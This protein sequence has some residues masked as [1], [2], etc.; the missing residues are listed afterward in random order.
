[1]KINFVINKDYDAEVFFSLL[2]NKHWESRISGSGIN[3]R[4]ASKIHNAK[5]K[6][7]SE[8]LK[9]EFQKTVNKTYDECLPYI[10]KS[11][12]SYQKSWDEIMDDFSDTVEELTKPWFY[13]E[14][15]CVVTHFCRGISNWNGN[16]I[17]RS[18]K[19]NPFI[20]RRITAHEIILAHYFSIHRNI[21]SDSGLK[22]R[23]I[24]VLAEIAAFALTGLEPKLI[25]FWPWD[26]KSYYTD[27]NYPE[28][29]DLQL[30]LKEPFLKRKSF[31]EYIKTG[32]EAVKKLRYPI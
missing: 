5:T 17:G 18:W 21:Y 4:L 32:I 6:R 9:K 23:Q 12:E 15:V 8:L 16:V 20:Q 3:F 29:V 27:H 14:Y 26:T 24:W 10:E 2:Q 30:K 19:E 22:E 7:A 28:L 11:K 31:D 13:K 25:K 1:M